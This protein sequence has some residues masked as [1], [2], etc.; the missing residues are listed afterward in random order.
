MLMTD[1]Y[2][3]FSA[4][5]RR[6]SVELRSSLTGAAR[7]WASHADK[8][9]WPPTCTMAVLMEAGAELRLD[10]E[11]PLADSQIELESL[12][13]DTLLQ[14]LG[15]VINASLEPVEERKIDGG[16]NFDGSNKMMAQCPEAERGF[17]RAAR[18]VS[19]F[20]RNG[21]K[22]A[23]GRGNGVRIIVGNDGSPVVLQ[24]AAGGYA[25]G[26]TLRKVYIDAVP[27]PAG[28]LVR[29]GLPFS[30][31]DKVPKS[32]S[33]ASVND[34]RYLSFM[35]PTYFAMPPDERPANCLDWYDDLTGKER[36]AIRH[37]SIEQIA[38]T[39]RKAAWILIDRTEQAEL[40]HL[41]LTSVYEPLPA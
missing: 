34:V 15:S 11:A 37:L 6:Q 8:N 24:K 10:T 22:W 2:D 28:S 41:G 32:V 19:S 1:R 29:V 7:T 30:D 26:L 35:R 20:A 39:A 25:S 23:F 18:A 4:A 38:D 17:V 12:P 21:K 16:L 31:E 27:Y 33:L 14:A 9:W 13:N 3:E 36:D 5:I 40:G